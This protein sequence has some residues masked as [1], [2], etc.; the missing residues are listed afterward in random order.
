MLIATIHFHFLM[1]KNY[2]VTYRIF[3]T[4]QNKIQPIPLKTFNFKIV[5]KLNK[6]QKIS[7]TENLAKTLV[8]VLCTLRCD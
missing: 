4:F 5:K 8:E 1:Q 2:S 3:Q 7:I 6:Q